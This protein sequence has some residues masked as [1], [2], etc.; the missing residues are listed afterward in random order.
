MDRSLKQKLNGETIKLTDNMN[1]VYLKDS[2]RKFHPN[3]YFSAFQGIVSKTDHMIRNK[4]SLDRYK[5]I[6]TTTCIL[7]DH[8]GLRLDF[9]NRNN[10]KLTYSWKLKSFLLNDHLVREE[11]KKNESF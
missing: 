8:H 6:E 1:R 4:A 5:K 3:M 10:R 2:Y 11:I 9:N 7:S